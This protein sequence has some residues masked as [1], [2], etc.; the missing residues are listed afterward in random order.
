MIYVCNKLW[1]AKAHSAAR[2]AE[3][4]Y[5]QAK[6]MIPGAPGQV[7]LM[8]LG[9]AHQAK[10]DK[11]SVFLRQVVNIGACLG[12]PPKELSIASLEQ[13]HFHLDIKTVGEYML[14]HYPGKLLAGLQVEQFHRE[15]K[16]FWTAFAKANPAHP[17]FTKHQ[18]H[19]EKCVPVKIHSDEGTGLRKS[20]VYQFS[21]GPVLASSDASWD[22]YF[23]WTCIAHESYKQSNAGFEKGNQVLDELA[24]FFADQAISVF[25]QPITSSSGLEIFL[26][27]VGHEG[28]LP[29]QARAHHIKRNFNCAPN[30]MCPWCAA[31]DKDIPYTDHRS[32]AVWV[33]TIGLQRPWVRE[34][35]FHRVPGADHEDFLVKDLFHL[36]HLGAVRGFVVNLL[37]Y[38]CF[39]D[40]F[41][42]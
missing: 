35:P 41:A 13:K 37:C 32:T 28:D 10:S 22:R 39:C 14:E 33:R 6:T 31:D 30:A 36:C 1:Q 7:E 25:E 8:Q 12:I 9:F 26:V 3:T 20:A 23:F 40:R 4:A 27:F 38:L 15:A 34:S 11:E 21:W 42:S 5:L 16:R 2:A 18:N 29:A 19:L 24:S 17:V